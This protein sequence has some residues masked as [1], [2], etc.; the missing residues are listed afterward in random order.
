MALVKN[1]SLAG[2]RKMK[3]G[4]KGVLEAVSLKTK[5]KYVEIFSRLNLSRDRLFF[6]QGG[7][8]KQNLKIFKIE[9]KNANH[10]FD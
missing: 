7:K 9:I 10:Y 1:S 6:F 3:E 4:G 8:K 2:V 5:K